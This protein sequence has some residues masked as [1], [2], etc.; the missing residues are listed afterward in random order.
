MVFATEAEVTAHLLQAPVCEISSVVPPDGFTSGQALLISSKRRVGRTIED[1]WRALFRVLF[2]ED[3][4]SDIP[5]PYHD[6]QVVDY[7]RYLRREL[8]RQVQSRLEQEVA[9]LSAPV[10]NELRA[11]LDSIYQDILRSTHLELFE[12]YR[13]GGQQATQTR[14]DASAAVAAFGSF[15]PTTL[16]DFD[17]ITGGLHL[18]QGAA[19]PPPSFQLAAQIAGPSQDLTLLETIDPRMMTI[20]AEGQQLGGDIYP[21]AQ[22]SGYGSSN[23]DLLGFEVT[24]SGKNQQDRGEEEADPQIQSHWP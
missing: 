19:F 6:D 13:A 2:P 10:E 16:T 7:D 18:P 3:N 9:T 15:M 11:R 14:S 21:T 4:E 5:S 1:K 20:G 12:R 22:D 17:G 8:S 23:V 24:E